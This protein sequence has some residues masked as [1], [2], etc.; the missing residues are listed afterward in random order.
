[1]KFREDLFAGITDGNSDLSHMLRGLCTNKIK[2]ELPDRPD[3][4]DTLTPSYAP[5]CKRIIITD[6]YYPTLAR[7]NVHLETRSI[8][9]ITGTG[10]KV[11]EEEQE[12][13][14]IVLATGFKTVEFLHP[15]RIY[16]TNGRSLEDI[17][18]NGA[19]ALKGVAVEDLP[20][21]GM[22]YGP[23]TNLG[24]EDPVPDTS[25]LSHSN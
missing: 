25:Y 16:G 10:I 21:F 8:G 13:D 5:G 3:L 4:W 17:W 14:L 6:D 7:E 1:M 20:N 11:D 23:N 19:T 15:I 22:F 18:R 12:H 2:S 9:R 24:E